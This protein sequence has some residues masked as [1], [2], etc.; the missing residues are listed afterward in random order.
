MRASPTISSAGAQIS[1]DITYATAISVLSITQSTGLS[2]NINA[3]YGA[4]GALFRPSFIR[5]ASN[6]TA[7]VD[8]SSE[9]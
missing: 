8:F 7:F 6:N 1:D 2:M 4:V 3:T 5:A 9:L